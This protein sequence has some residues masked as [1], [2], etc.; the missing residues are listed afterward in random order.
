MRWRRLL[1]LWMLLAGLVAVLQFA[2]TEWAGGLEPVE[3]CGE[4]LTSHPLLAEVGDATQERWPPGVRCHITECPQRR[5][6]DGAIAPDCR[7]D[8]AR[9]LSVVMAADAQ[10]WAFLGLSSLLAGAVLVPL[11]RLGRLLRRR[12][13]PLNLP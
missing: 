12:G 7:G 13:R 5:I 6:G 8:R 4:L 2:T 11:V 1:G 9:H 3:R 10:D